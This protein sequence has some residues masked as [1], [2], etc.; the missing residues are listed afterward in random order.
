MKNSQSRQ[1]GT[2]AG[3]VLVEECEAY[4]EGRYLEWLEN[5]GK[6]IPA[7]A[8]LNG[9]AHGE[10]AVVMALATRRGNRNDPIQLV[11]DLASAVLHRM[12][13]HADS[14]TAV[15]ESRLQPLEVK[16]HQYAGAAPPEDAAEL[17]R[18]LTSGL[19]R[20]RRRR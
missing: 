12:D 8:W 5:A 3:L 19:G 13:Q 17:A 6:P 15:Q 1:R 20:F 7:W 18:W 10:P 16:L 9:L 4:L 14:L 11:A 2:S